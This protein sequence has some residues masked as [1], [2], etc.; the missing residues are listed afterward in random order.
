M[1]TLRITAL[2]LAAGAALF[3]AAQQAQAT[4]PG[5]NG[6]IA[7]VGN[8]SGT[9]QLYTMDPDG[10][11]QTQITS[12]PATTWELWLPAFSPDGRKILF[13]R[14]TPQNPC[15][16]DQFPLPSCINLYVI[17]SDGAG[18]TQLTSDNLSWGGT[19]SPD[20][21]QIVFN[22]ISALTHLGVVTTMRADGSGVQP[23][24]TSQLWDSDFGRYTPDGQKFVFYS[25][26]GGFVSAVWSMETDGTHQ[27]RL[28][29][30]ALEGSPTD[31]SPDGRHILLINHQNTNIPPAIFTMKLDGDDLDQLTY[32]P[33]NANDIG[34]GYSPDGKKIVFLSNRLTPGSLDIFTMNVDG[35]DIQRV[36]FGLTVGGCP[37]GNCVGATWGPKPSH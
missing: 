28:T 8:Q 2:A 6:K 33:G 16:L 10:S 1:R 31:I 9:W 37:D 13:S 7:F 4:F 5:Q 29:H 12:L 26:N 30:A 36:A 19:W 32:P 18:L 20:G 27:R 35:T 3:L 21:S 11:N 14:D 25:Q 34:G 17:N 15:P 23:G 24:L 22:H